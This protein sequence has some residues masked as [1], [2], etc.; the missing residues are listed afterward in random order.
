MQHYSQELELSVIGVIAV[1]YADVRQYIGLLQP[2]DFYFDLP[3]AVFSAYSSAQSGDIDI[4]LVASKLTQEQSD[5]LKQGIA[6]VYTSANFPAYVSELKALSQARRLTAA[7]T[8]MI[9]GGEVSLD[10]LKKLVQD[11]ESNNF[12]L[13]YKDKAMRS[14]DDHVAG[15]GVKPKRIYTGLSKLDK[16]SGGIRVPSVFMVGAYPSV[17]KTAFALNIAAN[18]DKPVVFFSLEMSGGMIY[19]RLESAELKIDYGLFSAWELGAGY[20]SVITEYAKDL[21]NRVYCFDDV[22]HVEQ[23]GGIIASIKPAAVFVD[24]VQKV[25]THVKTD[26]RRAEIDYISGMYKRFAKDYDCVIFLLSQL[27]RGSNN[28]NAPTM[29]SLKESG[30]LEADGDY[31][32]ILHRPYVFDKK[33]HGP[34][35]A[36]LL[37]DKNKFGE[38]GVFNLHFEGRYQKF[39]EAETSADKPNNKNSNKAPVFTRL[40]GGAPPPQFAQGRL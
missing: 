23:H 2:E 30:A 35:E 31:V 4:W 28:N 8:A 25:R 3:R 21:K 26:S 13:S 19:E 39:Y 7:A 6:I 14:I 36:V 29:S 11:E 38:T 5:C 20:K 9:S 37:L 32:G 17:G 10:K 12:S 16:M 18:Q 24:Y 27:A 34:E 22:Y 1:Y 33:N 15:L 40:E